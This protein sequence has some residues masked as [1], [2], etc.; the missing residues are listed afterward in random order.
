MSRGVPSSTR[1]KADK[2]AFGIAI[3]LAALAALIF[4]DAS[5]LTAVAN[6][7]RIGPATIPI[8]IATCLLGL[9]VWTAIAARAGDFP[10][11]E[12]QQI[13]PAAWVVGGLVLQML[14]LKTLGF[15]IATGLLFAMTAAAFGKRKL[16]I[17][18]PLGIVLCLAIWL[19]FAG[20][21]QLSLPAGPL[22]HLLRR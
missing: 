2:A 22:E 17:T 5:R 14:C 13:A 1:P 9:A 18:I 15:S 20:L 11:R 10:A 6:Y 8:V 3:F 16:Y 4:W 7:S 21:L 19:L 12:R